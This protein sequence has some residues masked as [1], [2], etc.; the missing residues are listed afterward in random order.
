MAWDDSLYVDTYLPFGLRSVPKL[1]NVAANLLQWAMQQQGIANILHNFLTLGCPSSAEFQNNLDI[2]KQ[3]CDALGVPLTAE[4]VEGPSTSLTFLDITINTVKMEIRLCDAKLSRIC[5]TVSNWI[6]KRKAKE[7]EMLSL[8]GLLQHAT[9]VVPC[10][11]TFVR[12]IRTVNCGTNKKDHLQ[13][14]SKHAFPF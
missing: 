13:K 5:H 11:K 4:K 14:A 7:K 8:V 10:G 9:K 3:N 6:T 1:F 12:R 2:I